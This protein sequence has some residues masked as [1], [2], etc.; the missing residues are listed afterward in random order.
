MKVRDMPK[1]WCEVCR[2][3]VGLFGLMWVGIAALTIV[4][5]FIGAWT[6]LSWMSLILLTYS[7]SLFLIAYFEARSHWKRGQRWE[8]S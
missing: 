7:V 8:I 1:H 2:I 3:C 5:L 6:A 4:T